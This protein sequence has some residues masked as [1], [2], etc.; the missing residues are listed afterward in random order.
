M[1]KFGKQVCVLGAA[2]F[3]GKAVVPA[4]AKAGYEVVVPVRRPERYRDF[5]LV[6]NVKVVPLTGYTNQEFNQL[7]AGKSFVV[8]LLADQSNSTETVADKELVSVTQSIKKS[9]ELSGVQRIIQ[10]SQIGANASQAW[11]SWLRILG[12]ADNVMHNSASVLTTI[13]RPGVLLGANDNTTSLYKAQ[14]ERCSLMMVPNA[15]IQIQPLAIEDFAK[16]LVSCMTNPET[17]NLRI[18][19]AGEESMSVLDLAHWVGS[20]L[21]KK[22]SLILPMCSLNAKFMVKL[23]FLAPFKTTNAY[24]QK[25]L[26][27]D[28]ISKQDFATTFGFK[29]KSIETIL[30]GY[31]I[32]QGLR[33][34]YG[35]FREQAGRKQVEFE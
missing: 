31:V 32:P 14:L 6:P 4:L 20:L 12:E 30:A 33:D 29:P 5:G 19:L 17:F 10:L 18:E 15:K 25:Q 16:A 26:V 11:S 28:L 34:R 9:A 7:F 8:N 23:G 2:G 1:V 3:I 24:Q 22:A 27:T 21:D 35:F 13:L